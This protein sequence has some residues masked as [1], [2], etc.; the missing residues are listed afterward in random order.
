MLLR[1]AIGEEIMTY[2]ILDA[3][4]YTEETKQKRIEEAVSRNVQLHIWSKKEIENYF[5]VPQAIFRIIAKKRAP[6][7]AGPTVAEIVAKIE[8]IALSLKEETKD[9]IAQEIYN[10]D[11]SKGIA[12]ANKSARIKVDQA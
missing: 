6:N 12:S 5:V 8:E 1:N 7:I 4:Y 10:S 11:K 9:A 2:C 3:D